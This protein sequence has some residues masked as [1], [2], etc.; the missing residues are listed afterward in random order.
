MNAR[1]YIKMPTL[2]WILFF[3]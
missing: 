2:R 1:R 3:C